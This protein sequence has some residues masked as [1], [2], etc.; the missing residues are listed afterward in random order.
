MLT[1]AQMTD[2]R[3]YAGYWIVGTTQPVNANTDTVY[4]R[5][6]MTYMSLWTRLTT[7]SATEEAV[8]IGTYLTNLATLETAIVGASANLDTDVA[9]VWTHNKNEVADRSALFDMWRRK[10]CQFLGLPPGPGIGGGANVA[11]VRG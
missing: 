8:L 5:F 10:M 9:A 7:L 1:D 6:G 4:M 3:R 11:I 2:V